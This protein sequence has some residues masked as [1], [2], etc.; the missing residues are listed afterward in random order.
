MSEISN[1]VTREH[2]VATNYLEQAIHAV[3]KL[4]RKAE[5]NNLPPPTLEVTDET[6]VVQV[7]VYEDGVEVDP[8]FKVAKTKIVVTGEFPRF[9]DYQFLAKIDHAVSDTGNVVLSPNEESENFLLSS[10]VDYHTCASGCDHCGVSR[11]R[12]D[13]YL[14]KKVDS[15]DILQIGSTC[16][17]DYLGKQTLNQVVNA[18]DVNAIFYDVKYFDDLNNEYAGRAFRHDESAI[19]FLALAVEVTDKNGFQKSGSVYPTWVHVN[20]VLYNSSHTENIEAEKLVVSAFNAKQPHPSIEKAEKV[21]EWIMSQDSSNS[22]SMYIKNIQ[23]V[24]AAGH[25]SPTDSGGRWAAFV[26]SVPNSY[27]RAMDLIRRKEQEAK[28]PQLNEPFG[29]A[30]KRGRLKLT[31]RKI[32]EPDPFAAFPG[33]KYSLVDDAGRSFNW[34]C[35]GSDPMMEVGKSYTVTGTIKSHSEF[36]GNHYTFLTRC[37]DFE[38]VESDAP[39][40]DFNAKIKPVK[41]NTVTNDDASLELT[42]DPQYLEHCINYKRSWKEGRKGYSVDIIIPVTHETTED[43]IKQRL[44]IEYQGLGNVVVQQINDGSDDTIAFVLE[45]AKS[46]QARFREPRTMLAE[47][48]QNVDTQLLNLDSSSPYFASYSAS[49]D[50][51]DPSFTSHFIPLREINSADVGNLTNKLHSGQKGV[52]LEFE[53]KKT[54]Y[55]TNAEVKTL[56][57]QFFSHSTFLKKLSDE[58]YDRLIIDKNGL[59]RYYFPAL[60]KSSSDGFML[61]DSMKIIHRE[62][63]LDKKQIENLSEI[64]GKKMLAVSFG[65][66]VD[67]SKSSN[68]VMNE[69]LSRTAEPTKDPFVFPPM[70]ERKDGTDNLSEIINHL[71]KKLDENRVIHMIG[72][73]PDMPSI[74]KD[75]GVNIQ[76]LHISNSET[77]SPY[78]TN[79][80]QQADALIE[81]DNT[82]LT[83]ALLNNID[84]LQMMVSNI[85][86]N[87]AAH[88]GLSKEQA[89]KMV[90]GCEQL[91]ESNDSP[92]LNWM[93]E[94][95]NRITIELMESVVSNV[96]GKTPQEA[97]EYLFSFSEGAKSYAV[98][99]CREELAVDLKLLKESP[100]TPGV[101]EK[102][103][104][105]EALRN[106]PKINMR[107]L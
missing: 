29:E 7:P 87:V 93:G 53:A 30:K 63:S 89:Q 75:L 106:K 23:A 37:S 83:S 11:K 45:K 27:N 54:L 9:S 90:Y 91:I 48:T 100:P 64:A 59:K 15:D 77:L 20:N 92:L 69:L 19:L 62:F 13:T 2:W 107:K 71:S 38:E 8:Q 56:M 25:F 18:F 17:D 21:Y 39:A 99:F 26:A 72:V 46:I 31:V 36:M 4:R 73:Q 104:V 12:N 68:A 49:T 52:Q 78:L 86:K 74:L 51:R 41:K 96:T 5:R 76:H 70:V 58:G 94:K 98:Q 28:M 44:I 10:G 105:K 55:M 67:F 24:L 47:V 81:C 50:H 3:E 22:K 43:E 103:E 14:V 82:D 1:V 40:P 79:H 35:S 16:V 101:V 61:P 88:V 60:T 33:K 102:L 65:T 34:K 32:K 57:D 6:R 84:K 97:S 80:V 66:Q 95:Q 42:V 85:E